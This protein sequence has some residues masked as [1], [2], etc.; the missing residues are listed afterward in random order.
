MGQSKHLP[1]GEPTRRSDRNTVPGDEVLNH[2]IAGLVE[3][4][5]VRLQR[6]KLLLEGIADVHDKRALPVP[7]FGIER[8]RRVDEL[9]N[10]V[11]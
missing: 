4:R 9:R 5:S 1:I 3:L 6:G 11:W 10:A 7:D 2:F 8:N